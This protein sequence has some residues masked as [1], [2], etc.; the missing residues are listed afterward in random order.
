MKNNIGKTEILIVNT[1]KANLKNVVIKVKDEGEQINLK[2][3]THIKILGVIIDDQLNWTKQ[4]NNVKRNSF[5]STRNLHRINHLLPIKV[6]IHLYN[7]LITPHFDYADVVWGGCG[8]TNS[9][10]L[11]LVQNFAAKSITGNRKYDSAT[12]SLQKLKFLNLQQRRN[13]HEAVFVHKSILQ[14]NPSNINTEYLQQR[15]TSNTRQSHE[16]KLNLP[17]HRTSKYE[18]SPFYRT[19]KSWNSCPSNIPTGNPKIHKTL[20]QKY[21]IKQTYTAI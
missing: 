4:V 16:G 9:K 14:L 6:K 11:Q 8:K 20:L 7:A 2:P 1:G 18:N 5:N 19:I 12:N 3:K 15:P 17:T 13:I 21:L 10:K